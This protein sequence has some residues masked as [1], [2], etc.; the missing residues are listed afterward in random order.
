MIDAATITAIGTAAA[1][2]IGA[3]GV[4]V[5]RVIKEL[6][7]LRSTTVATKEAV[8][9]SKVAIDATQ[10]TIDHTKAAI[11]TTKAAIDDTKIAV[12]SV[13]KDAETAVAQTNGNLSKLQQQISDTQARTDAQQAAQIERL[14]ARYKELMDHF[15][16][17]TASTSAIVVPVLTPPPSAATS[18]S[19]Q[20]GRRAD[21]HPKP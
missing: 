18:E 10:K 14:E 8:D 9:Q 17:A 19:A 16:K 3:I 1:V 6:R 2:V 12:A 21:D 13:A 20:G 15:T 4:A 11:D 5:A 7:D